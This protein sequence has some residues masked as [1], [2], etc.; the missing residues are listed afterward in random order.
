M[1]LNDHNPA[2]VTRNL[3]LLVILALVADSSVAAELAL[4]FWYSAWLPEE[5]LEQIFAT[6]A[7]MAECFALEDSAL[8]IA[9]GAQSTIMGKFERGT[10]MDLPWQLSS[11]HELQKANREIE[12]VRVV[13]NILSWY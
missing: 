13:P 12:R 5:Y 3:I 7:V 10:M 1:L 11:R 2:I 9:F 8:N 4:H 6:Q